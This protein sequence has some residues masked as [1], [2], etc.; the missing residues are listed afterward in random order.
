MLVFFFNKSLIM[1]ASKQGKN[2]F[3]TNNLLSSLGFETRLKGNNSL[4]LFTYTKLRNNFD[5]PR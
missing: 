4:K 3:T 5:G 2:K 1:E